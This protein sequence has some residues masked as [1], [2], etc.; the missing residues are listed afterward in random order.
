MLGSSRVISVLPSQASGYW[1]LNCSSIR[2]KLTGNPFRSAALTLRIQ[3]DEVD[4]Q[5]EHSQ[6]QEENEL[7]HPLL[8]FG[9][10]RELDRVVL[11]NLVLHWQI[12]KKIIEKRAAF[13]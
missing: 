8:D 13:L 4:G 9:P 7:N 1:K 3:I 5:T 2:G 12:N 11:R 6:N 10:M